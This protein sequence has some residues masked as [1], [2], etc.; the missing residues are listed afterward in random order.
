[1]QQYTNGDQTYG[2]TE[3]MELTPSAQSLSSSQYKN[4][5]AQQNGISKE[6]PTSDLNQYHIQSND[7]IMNPRIKAASSE[8]N[9]RNI[10]Q[11]NSNTESHQMEPVVASGPTSGLSS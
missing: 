10:D 5:P 8:G 6:S 1:M 11:I 2:L 7:S 9:Q 4:G 3:A